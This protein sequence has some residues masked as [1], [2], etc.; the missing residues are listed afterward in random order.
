MSEDKEKFFKDPEKSLNIRDL[1]LNLSSRQD[2]IFDNLIQARNFFKKKQGDGLLNRPIGDEFSSSLRVLLK[3][4]KKNCYTNFV[5]FLTNTLK[6]IRLH[7]WIFSW[8][9]YRYGVWT[10]RLFFSSFRCYV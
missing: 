7:H 1:I 10:N 6:V 3:I 9:W 2:I 5:S 4:M 8:C